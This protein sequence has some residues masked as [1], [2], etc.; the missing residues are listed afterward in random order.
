[1]ILMMVEDQFYSKQL[2]SFKM[3]FLL[4]AFIFTSSLFSLGINESLLSIH[5]T[6]VPKI[7]LMDYKFRD[8]LNNNAI[9]VIIFYD[10][11]EY[12]N[13][14]VLQEKIQLKYNKGIKNYPVK[15]TLVNYKKANIEKANIYYL[16]PS[17]KKNINK[18]LK[19]SAK[20]GA[21]T[22]AYSSTD[23]AQGCMIA[24]N[25]GTKVKPIINLNAIK[26]HHIELR[27]TLLKISTI[28]SSRDSL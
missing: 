15:T 11:S 17:N 10:S 14:R 4:L 16:F 7:P 1:M 18:V 12:K 3:R 5:A 19:L 6:L 26:L 21:I 25:I 22:F 27:P 24:L 28:Y 23:L 9:S 2:G 8:K 20:N 13:A